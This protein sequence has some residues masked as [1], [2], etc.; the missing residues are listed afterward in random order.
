MDKNKS[1]KAGGQVEFLKVAGYWRNIEY[2]SCS[3]T[4]RRG[5][6]IA[7]VQQ[8]GLRLLGPAIFR[9]QAVVRIQVL[10]DAAESNLD[11]VEE[12]HGLARDV[13][14]QR[15][16]EDE[17]TRRFDIDMGEYERSIS[18]ALFLFIIREAPRFKVLFLSEMSHSV[19]V[20]VMPII[21]RQSPPFETV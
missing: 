19:F 14:Q 17:I 21:T 3:A 10:I 12:P 4:S 5:W 2:D 1:K 18:E 20:E 6:E 8:P 11:I 9:T 13:R 7:Q 15:I 16:G